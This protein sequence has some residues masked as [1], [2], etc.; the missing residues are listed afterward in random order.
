MTNPFRG[1]FQRGKDVF[2]RVEQG[3]PLDLKGLADQLGIPVD[4]LEKNNNLK[5]DTKLHVGQELNLGQ[6]T[7]V[8][9][10][11]NVEYKLA[12]EY[13]HQGISGGAGTTT[14]GGS[15]GNS[16]GSGA[17]PIGPFKDGWGT[18]HQSPLA[19]SGSGGSSGSSSGGAGLV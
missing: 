3:D 1:L 16:S 13:G 9:K 6:G 17:A 11:D 5:A 4:I 14:I 8:V 18:N 12:P 2:E 10:Q 15:A 7:V 19:S